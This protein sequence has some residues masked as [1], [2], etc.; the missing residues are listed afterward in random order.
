[1]RAS[2]APIGP[3]GAPPDAADPLAHSAADQAQIDAAISLVLSNPTAIGEL[4]ARAAPDDAR[5][6][7]WT[8]FCRRLFLQVLAERGLVKTACEY[9]GLTRQSAYALAARDPL[10]AAG[11]DAAAMLARRPLADDIFEKS[12]DGVTDTITRNGE[13]VAT[14]HRYDGRLSVAVLNRLDRRCDRAEERGDKHLAL[15]RHWDEYL[16]HVGT[17]DDE[18][19]RALLE[20]RGADAAQQCQ[21]CQLPESEDGAEAAPQ[22]EQFD[23]ERR[24]WRDD[25]GT[26]ITDFPPPPGFTGYESGDFG[27]DDYQRECSEEEQQLL[28][29][30][31]KLD[32]DHI[33]AEDESLRDEWLAALRQELGLDEQPR[34]HDAAVP[35]VPRKG[36]AS[37]PPPKVKS[38]AV[39][40]QT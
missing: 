6:D 30:V 5:P 17:G 33:R 11:W 31:E 27:Q 14:R 18:A 40:S 20:T 23:L 19:A 15:M 21:P 1:L 24:Y 32:V 9:T 7:G 13:I 34:A 16:G 22:V 35:S 28:N 12:V 2:A 38:P 26:W 3:P 39:K 37:V 8:P 10:F 36:G 25:E 4:I 29:G